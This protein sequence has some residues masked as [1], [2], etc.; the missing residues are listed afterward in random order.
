MNTSI[1][2]DPTPLPSPSEVE[3]DV[4]LANEPYIEAPFYTDY[5]YNLHLG[6]QIY[7]NFNCT[8][9][10]SCA[11]Y[12]GPRTLLGPNVS[13]YTA[14]HTTDPAVRD[15]LR[16]PEFG[17]EIRIGEDCWIGGSVVVL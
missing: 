9:L 17:K 4:L 3:D 5:G 7:I 2:N 11:V 1:C 15:G 13:L 8:I 14:S 6:E 10:D 16:G 12:I